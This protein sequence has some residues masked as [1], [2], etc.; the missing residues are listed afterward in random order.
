MRMV[1]GWDGG[2]V[3]GGGGRVIGGVEGGGREGKV[4]MTYSDIPSTSYIGIERDQ[5]RKEN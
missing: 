1:K 2:G 3:I 4:H 5:P